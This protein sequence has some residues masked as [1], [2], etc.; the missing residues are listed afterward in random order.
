MQ[1]VYYYEDYKHI[2][3]LN[4]NI[5]YMPLDSPDAIIMSEA[6]EALED[7]GHIGYAFYGEGGY[8]R[9][10]VFP[11][12]DRRRKLYLEIGDLIEMDSCGYYTE[13]NNSAKYIMN[14]YVPCK[15]GLHNIARAI[16]RKEV[17][18]E[19]LVEVFD[20]IK[21]EHHGKPKYKTKFIN[22]DRG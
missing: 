11:R 10:C 8:H 18:K 6:T 7:A 17:W 13:L 1:L 14:V 21:E 20:R 4:G 12:W 22:I 9:L 2:C 16:A 3:M 19:V 15:R 5:S